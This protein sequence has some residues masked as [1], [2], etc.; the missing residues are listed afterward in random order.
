MSIICTFRIKQRLSVAAVIASSLA[1]ACALGGCA[2]GPRLAV[3]GAA[4]TSTPVSQGA[5]PLPSASA[6]PSAPAPATTPSAKPV[7]GPSG[8]AGKPGGALTISD[9]SDTVLINGRQVDFCVPVHDLAWSPDGTRA[10]FIDG[11]GNLVVSNA[12]GGDRIEVAANPGGQE[13]SHPTWLVDHTPGYPTTTTTLLMFTATRGGVSVLK[14]VEVGPVRGKVLTAPLAQGAGINVQPIP[15]TGNSWPSAEI[16]P[17]GSA[18]YEHDTGH[19]FEVYHRDSYSRQ[20]GGEMFDG[21]EPAD[22]FNGGEVA[23]IRSVDGHEHL[24]VADLD[25]AD[26]KITFK[27]LTPKIT[28]NVSAPAWSPDGRT[29]AFATPGAVWTI[30]ANGSSAGAATRVASTDGVPSYQ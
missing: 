5:V 15:Q 1:A 8:K 19:G 2:S 20:Q 24:F 17:Y 10:A 18:V 21:A 11:D 16:Q 12:V 23:F 22:S 14:E 9:G 25:T 3:A 27:D 6:K 28:V 26:G 29:I 13:W 7:C 30:A 4:A